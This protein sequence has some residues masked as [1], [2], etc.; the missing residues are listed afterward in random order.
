MIK[1]FLN[2]CKKPEGK[3]GKWVVSAMNKGHAP[4]CL[5]A[6][7][8][9]PLSDGESVLELD[10]MNPTYKVNGVDLLAEYKE[11]C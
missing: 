3:F 8:V 6:F 1:K 7:E 2:N 9:C 11:M 5:W 10:K 4:L